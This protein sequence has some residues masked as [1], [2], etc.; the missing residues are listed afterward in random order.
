MYQMS[1]IVVN[2]RN[3]TVSIIVILST[4]V[5]GS[6]DAIPRIT[7]S[8]KV[9]FSIVAAMYMTYET[10]QYQFF[11]ESEDDYVIE[12]QSTGSTISS[13]SLL[14]GYTRIITIFMWKQ[15]INAYRKNE[16]C[17]SITH[18][19]YIKWFNSKGT[20]VETAGTGREEMVGVV[21]TERASVVPNDEEK[22]E[23]STEII[24]AGQAM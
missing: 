4:A 13:H 3:I 18:I 20:S 22:S 8:L 2:I 15:G 10:M 21:S 5:I 17:I 16:R 9:G 6:L 7:K 19:P 24:V 23:T 14:A 1:T 12:I 11:K